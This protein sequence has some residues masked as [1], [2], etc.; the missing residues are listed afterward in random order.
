MG[1]VRYYQRVED[2]VLIYEFFK[3]VFLHELSCYCGF[4]L[5]LDSLM[6]KIK[7]NHFREIEKCSI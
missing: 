3:I 1:V 7:L 2:V 6:V 4:K 5:G